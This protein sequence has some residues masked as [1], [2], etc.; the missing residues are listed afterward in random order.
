MATVGLGELCPIQ[1]PRIVGRCCHNELMKHPDNSTLKELEDAQEEAEE[2]LA[3]SG[4]L[5]GAVTDLRNALEAL[6][7]DQEWNLNRPFQA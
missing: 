4:A 1:Q 2:L 5:V 7:I 6:R 3:I